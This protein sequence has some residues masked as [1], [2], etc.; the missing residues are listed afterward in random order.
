MNKIINLSIIL[1]S[2]ILINSSFQWAPIFIKASN[3]ENKSLKYWCYA[4]YTGTNST[5]YATLNNFWNQKIDKTAYRNNERFMIVGPL[6]GFSSLPSKSKSNEIIDE[7]VNHLIK[8][9]NYRL[10]KEDIEDL[11]KNTF[12][13]APVVADYELK[14]IKLCKKFFK[15]LE[16]KTSR[17][18]LIEWAGWE[19]N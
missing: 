7:F 8:K 10:T 16:K 4:S 1:S 5:S 6:Y 9:N 11:K 19:E 13:S 12:L 2:I 14:A 18:V 15:N 17:I 3:L